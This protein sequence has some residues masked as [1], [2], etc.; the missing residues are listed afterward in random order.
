MRKPLLVIAALA[1]I[2]SAPALF[3]GRANAV[4]NP[5]AAAIAN[6]LKGVNTTE[7]AAY[8]C[9][10]RCSWNGCSRRCRNTDSAAVYRPY[11]RWRAW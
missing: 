4:T 2:I 3:A 9:R 7:Q 5:L 10:R 6:A 8:V 11:R 1:A